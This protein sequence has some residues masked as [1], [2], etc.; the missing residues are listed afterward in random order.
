MDGNLFFSLNRETQDTAALNSWGRRN[1]LFSDDAYGGGAAAANG[2][3]PT[4][5]PA[6]PRLVPATA[7]SWRNNLVLARPLGEGRHGGAY[8]QANCLRCDDGASWFNSAP[9]NFHA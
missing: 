5:N 8:S 7:N 3:A 9:R 4:S 2:A 1:Y 6:T